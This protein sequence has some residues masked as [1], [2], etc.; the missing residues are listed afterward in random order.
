MPMTQII[1]M[2]N[3]W[4]VDSVLGALQLFWQRRHTSADPHRF[5]CDLLRRKIT[6][7]EFQPMRETL[8]ANLQAAGAVFHPHVAAYLTHLIL[9][10]GRREVR[11]PILT[12]DDLGNV[13]WLLVMLSDHLDTSPPLSSPPTWMDRKRYALALLR[14]MQFQEPPSHNQVQQRVNRYARIYTTELEKLHLPFD[15][16]RVFEVATGVSLPA[17]FA[18]L[19]VLITWFDRW[20]HRDANTAQWF[21]TA[22]LLTAVPAA[23][24]QAVHLLLQLWST[25]PA[26]YATRVAA[27]VEGKQ[28]ALAEPFDFVPLKERPIVEVHPGVFTVPV[29]QFLSEAAVNGPHFII[30]NALPS[31]HKDAYFQATGDAFEAYVQALS[32]SIAA[33]DQGGSW[34]TDVSPR[35]AAATRQVRGDELA[36]VYLQRGDVGVAIEAKALRF[37]TEFLSGLDSSKVVGPE[38]GVL[39]SLDDPNVPPPRPADLKRADKGLLTRSMYQHSA[40]GAGL[41][42]YTQR[43]HNHAPSRI[44]PLIVHLA[45]YRVERTMYQIYLQ[46]LVQRLNL[47]PHVFWWT[48]RWIHI[49]D[50]EILAGVAEAGQLDLATFL[51]QTPAST[52]T[53]QA[54]FERFGQ[55]RAQPARLVQENREQMK[56]WVEAMFRADESGSSKRKV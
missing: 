28:G 1:S 47:Y 48:P 51:E 56:M 3:S 2:L 26:D 45:E 34:T 11:T 32:Q 50:L 17:Y 7:P 6:G 21:N 25:T 44:Y 41:Q 27:W 9:L 43:V 39:T 10:H 54:L 40:A 13:A 22:E 36:D 16:G 38:D 12:E 23:E 18:T 14:V 29:V 20:A 19:S 46:P 31:H 52:R 15:P 24:H 5:E 8:E 30:L 4:P 37:P 53:D 55:I 42:A 35:N 49:E 33:D